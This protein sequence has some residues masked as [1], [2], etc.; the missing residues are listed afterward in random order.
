[1]NGKTFTGRHM[2][3]ILCS[4]FAVVI[5]V[6][7]AMARLASGTFGGVVVENSYVATQHFNRWLD[8]AEAGKALGWQAAIRR[9]GDGRV[10]LSLTGVPDGTVAVTALA[11]HP[12][13][14]MPD[15]SL[16]F[17]RQPDG[18]W[19]SASPL[20]EGRWRLRL[21]VEAAGLNWRHEEEMR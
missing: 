21:D 2:A 5:A 6:N 19:L 4:F 11:R 14:R 10:A 12:L 15:R 18:S 1:M 7:L 8:E 16:T 17:A 13:G 20:P 3:A 9:A